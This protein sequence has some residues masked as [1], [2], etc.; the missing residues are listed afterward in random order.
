MAV[1]RSRRKR[2]NVNDIFVAANYQ[3]EKGNLRSAFR[4]FLSGAKAGDAG[5]QVNLGF[6]YDTGIGVKPNRGSAIYWYRRAYR[7]G[8]AIGA[9][10]IGTIWRDEGKPQRALAWFRRA[11]KMGDLDYAPEVAKILIERGENRKAT[12]SLERVIEAG[13][14]DVTQSSRDEASRLLRRMTK[15]GRVA[16]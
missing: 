1:K 10:N 15:A 11:V 5:A 9:G 3:W 7:M 13:R 6:F 4:L 16:R 8:S 12:A 14:A 2:Q